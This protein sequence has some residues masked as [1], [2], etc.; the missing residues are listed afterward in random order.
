MSN[1]K[2][3]SS[4]LFD[5]SLSENSYLN[6]LPIIKYL[7]ANKELK[8]SSNITFFVGENG[9]GKSTL[10]EAIAVAY[11]FNAEGGTRN[12]SFSPR[13]NPFCIITYIIL[14]NYFICKSSFVHIW[15]CITI[16]L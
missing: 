9:T 4:I 16:L 8:F 7:A 12:F 11:G 15:H 2:Y 14:F 5:N 13:R 3:I 6:D 10:L 1:A